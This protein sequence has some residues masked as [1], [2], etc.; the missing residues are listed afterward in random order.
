MA[1]TYYRQ[2]LPGAILEVSDERENQSVS[3]RTE[4]DRSVEEAPLISVEDE[5]YQRLLDV[6]ES[7]QHSFGRPPQLLHLSLPNEIE[8]PKDP[9]LHLLLFE[10]QEF[11]HQ[12]ASR[13]KFSAADG[14]SEDMGLLDQAGNDPDS[15]SK[16]AHVFNQVCEI[17]AFEAEEYQRHIDEFCLKK[18]ELLDAQRQVLDETVDIAAKQNGLQ[19]ATQA[20]EGALSEKESI[21]RQIRESEHEAE[22]TNFTIAELEAECGSLEAELAHLQLVIQEQTFSVKEV[23]HIGNQTV[24]IKQQDE[25][26]GKELQAA[27]EQ[28]WRERANQDGLDRDMADLCNTLNEHL[29]QVKLVHNFKC[30]ASEDACFKYKDRHNRMLDFS[31]ENIDLEESVDFVT[32]IKP[33]LDE[34]KIEYLERIKEMQAD[35][36]Q[37]EDNMS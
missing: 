6:A 14:P 1:R 3:Q 8:F 21:E 10:Y 2:A 19:E 12:P 27:E 18:E 13:A 5:L 9:L 22:Q 26:L 30:V 36:K 34:K 37:L 24:Q 17:I 28:I 15:Y 29:D 7:S 23:A 11:L 25:Q 35:F 4:T 32:E 31:S 33:L 16:Y 20:L